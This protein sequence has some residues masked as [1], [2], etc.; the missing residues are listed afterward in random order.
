MRTGQILEL[1][2]GES[3]TY[4]IVIKAK[5]RSGQAIGVDLTNKELWFYAKRNEQDLDEDAY[6]I[7][8]IG[9]GITLTDGSNGVA[10]LDFYSEDTS[11]LLDENMTIIFKWSLR[12]K[13]SSVNG[14]SI[15]HLQEGT[16]VVTPA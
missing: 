7:K 2:I 10:E 1:N 14:T 6:I 8:S 3:A 9:N 5:N 11:G 13:Y 15:K 4:S 12:L 16:L